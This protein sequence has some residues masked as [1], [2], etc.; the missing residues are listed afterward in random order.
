MNTKE[1]LNQN[2]LQQIREEVNKKLISYNVDKDIKEIISQGVSAKGN[3]FKLDYLQ[4]TPIE[5]FFK[6][7]TITINDL[8]FYQLTVKEEDD[9]FFILKKLQ[10]I[11]FINCIFY[12]DF[13]F[14]E[15]K[16]Y[17]FNSCIFEND[18]TISNCQTFENES[19]FFDCE[20]TKNIKIKSQI[21]N[22]ELFQNCRI[23]SLNV[24]NCTFNK[25]IVNDTFSKSKG[26]KYNK[27]DFSDCIINSTFAHKT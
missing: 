21:I 10:K 25:K 9:Y 11:E 16:T 2:L 24:Y 12:D 23:E 13:N 1:E 4:S 14:I 15:N 5:E 20:F 6:N 3:Y 17:H 26:V 7:I 8:T 22:V 18:L 19:L 27:L